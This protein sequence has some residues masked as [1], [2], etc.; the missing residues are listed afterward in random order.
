MKTPQVVDASLI[1]TLLNEKHSIQAFL[2]QLQNQSALPREIVI[3]DGG[4][5]DGTLQ[6]IQQWPPPHGVTIRTI[7]SPGSTIA[8][9]RNLAIREASSESILVTDGGTTLSRN[10]VRDLAQALQDGADVA[11]GFF[12]PGGGTE[13]ERSLA[14]IIL[15]TIHEIDPAKF[16]PSSRS[17]GIAKAS[18]RLVNGYPE[19]LDYC[20]DL[21][22]DIRLKRAGLTF[23]FVPDAIS[24]WSARPSLGAFFTQYFRYARG[25][26]KSRLF[27]ARH[28]TRYAAYGA[29]CL[30][31]IQ[32]HLAAYLLLA[33][34]ILFA[35]SK[36]LRRVR[37][38][39]ANNGTPPS[40]YLLAPIVLLLGDVAKMLGYVVG[41]A[42][43][44]R[45]RKVLEGT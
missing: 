17:L 40:A 42:W 43:R 7:L 24:T 13:F 31:L 27:A 28:F 37:Y 35:N 16:L 32:Q 39:Q 15:P 9:G 2:D 1:M 10:W 12:A 11:A 14:R 30:L 34:A 4:S 29:I 23:R 3:V 22:F 45:Y 26:G 5:T 19:W 6:T 21:L 25:D 20:E 36:Y 38:G 18:W 33:T 8:A 41:V 44:L